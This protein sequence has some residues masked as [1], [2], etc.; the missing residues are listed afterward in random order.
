M[1]C[2][3]KMTNF[4]ENGGDNVAN[5]IN[6]DIMKFESNP[7]THFQVISTYTNFNQ[8]LQPPKFIKKSRS[9]MLQFII[10][11]YFDS[12]KTLGMC[13]CIDGEI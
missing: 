7:V 1:N 4:T 8:K 3:F 10:K 13:N 12:Q 11:K 5:V 9:K 6:N 2:E